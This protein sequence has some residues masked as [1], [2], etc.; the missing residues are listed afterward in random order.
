MLSTAYQR[1]IAAFLSEKQ[2]KTVVVENTHTV[3]GGCINE[4]VRLQTSAGDYFVKWNG[5]P[6]FAG[7][8]ASRQ[9]WFE[10]EVE[11]LELLRSAGEIEVPE[12]LLC[13]GDDDRAFLL[14][15]FIHPGKRENNFFHDFGRRLAKLHR[16]S[17][18]KFGLIF[19][20]YI[21]SLPQSNAQHSTWPDFFIA[22]RLVPQI[23]LANA[24]IGKQAMEQVNLSTN[25]LFKQLPS[26]FPTEPPSLLHG[27]L[28]SGN[29]MTGTKGTACI[30]DPAVYYGHREMDIAMT[31]LFGG[32]DAS[33]YEG[34]NEE[35]PLEKGWEERADICN[36]YPLLVHVNLFG[37]SYLQDVKR[38]LARF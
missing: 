30:F 29:F 13:G 2:G 31:K 37:G 23:K 7:M 21:G 19:D 33:F 11:G 4:A 5:A 34:Y 24:Q 28:W 26:L 6:R 38:I 17:A 25:E 27:D 32:F 22:Q 9:G 14:L 15:Q 12:V 16:H 36:L 35:Y 18:A 1:Q 10:A 3:G 20:N 8:P